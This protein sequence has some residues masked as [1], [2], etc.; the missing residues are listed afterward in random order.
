VLLADIPFELILVV[1]AALIGVISRVV[2]FTKKMRARVATKMRD[3]EEAEGIELVRTDQDEPDR[4]KTSN[5]IVQRPVEFDLDPSWT[6]VPVPM[7]FPDPK[8]PSKPKPA[9]ESPL[10]L[11]LGGR[12]TVRTAAARPTQPPKRSR[13]AAKS[14]QATT[15]TLLRTLKNKRE[16]AMLDAR[17]RQRRLDTSLHDPKGVQ[18]AI[19]LREILGPP[20]AAKY[21]PHLNRRRHS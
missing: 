20:G 12:N 1:V 3:K 16:G 6:G 4:R 10:R 13:P 14:P 9:A 15:S 11:K 5:E 17:R 21:L 18:R 7:P 19:V 2:E 8:V